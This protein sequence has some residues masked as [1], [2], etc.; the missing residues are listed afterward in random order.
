MESLLELLS[1]P[2]IV[3]IT[4][5]VAMIIGVINISLTIKNEFQKRPSLDIEFPMEDELNCFRRSDSKAAKNGYLIAFIKLTNKSAL[6]LHVS[7]FDLYCDELKN[8]FDSLSPLYSVFHLNQLE[9]ITI[10]PETN[11]LRPNIKIEP[12]AS[13]QGFIYFEQLAVSNGKFELCVNTPQKTFK[14]GLL[15]Q[16]VT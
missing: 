11:I 3:A 14:T 5:Y 15:A 4:A 13:V 8:T 1:K 9:R 7:A 12:Y 6:P 2:Q 10:G 16:E